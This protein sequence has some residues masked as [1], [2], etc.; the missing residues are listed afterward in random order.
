MTHPQAQIA[1]IGGG[2]SGLTLARLLELSNIAYVVFER[3]E[4]AT[5]ADENQ[6][7]GT[8]DI[9]SDSGQVALQEAGLLEQFRDFARYGVPTKIVDSQGKVHTEFSAEGDEDKPEIDR[10]DLRNLLL[11]SVPGRKVRWGYKA[12]HLQKDSK[13][14]VSVH[15]TNGCVE[16]GFR[17]VVGADGAWSKARNM[18]RLAP[19]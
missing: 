12:Q 3:D 1:I 15:F 6:S 18:V 19:V 5:W 16:S 10:K 9:H 14:L 11:A 7:S 13:G 8:L 2:P 4:S 17:L